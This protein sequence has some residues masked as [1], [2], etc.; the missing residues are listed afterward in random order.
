MS[1]D[2]D[3]DIGEI[4]TRLDEL[5]YEKELADELSESFVDARDALDAIRTHPLVDDEV[6]AKAELLK[7][8]LQAIQRHDVHARESIYHER[9]VL[10]RQLAELKHSERDDERMPVRYEDGQ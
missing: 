8:M 6:A 9:D 4:E 10:R 2:T 1:A 7:H 5:D 3:A